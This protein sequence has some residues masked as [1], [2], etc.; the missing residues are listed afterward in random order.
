MDIYKKRRTKLLDKMHAGE[1]VVL[2]S[3]TTNYRNSD[4]YHKFRQNSDFWY[5]TGFPEA[6]AIAVLYKTKDTA[7]YWLFCQANSEKTEIWDGAVIGPRQAALQFGADKTFVTEKFAAGFLRL[8]ADNDLVEQLDLTVLWDMAHSQYVAEEEWIEM[9]QNKWI[10]DNSWR[11]ISHK[12]LMH[13]M[14]MLKDESEIQDIQKAVDVSVAAHLQAMRLASPGKHERDIEALLA[15]E[16]IRN[17]CSHAYPSIVAGGKNASILHYISNVSTLADGELLLLDAG[18]EYK[19]YAADITR[20]FPINGKF[21]EQQSI[22]YQLV[23]HAQEE[24]ISLIKPGA[25][26]VDVEKQVVT[27]LTEGLI[28]LGL[29]RGSMQDNIANKN[30]QKFYPHSFGHMLGLDV[31]DAVVF[32]D[33]KNDF[34]FEPGMVLT[35]EPGIY[36]NSKFVDV[37]KKWDGISVRIE[38]DVLVTKDGCRVLSDALP[39]SVQDIEQICMENF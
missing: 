35:V 2:F 26:W 4:V 37:D 38:D 28:D 13:Q 25:K 21:T 31:H 8:Y 36:I 7:G 20:T 10:L 18:A 22:I 15:Y 1:V 39:K 33:T 11:I 9:L 34:I 6:D 16:F 19:N 14:R 5:L 3:G 32:S 23:L 30:Y 12:A 17:D 24:G 29:L 27:C